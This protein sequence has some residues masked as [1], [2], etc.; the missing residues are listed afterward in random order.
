[1]QRE[2]NLV[3]SLAFNYL[4][5][6]QFQNVIRV[7]AS[8]WRPLW[9]VKDPWASHC[10]T[11]PVEICTMSF[12]KLE[13]S[14]KM[15]NN[16]VKALSH[17]PLKVMMCLDGPRHNYIRHSVWTVKCRA[18]WSIK[19]KPKSQFGLVWLC[20]CFQFGSLSCASRNTKCSNQLHFNIMWSTLV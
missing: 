8:S 10:R 13:M 2:A 4:T 16:T 9:L 5:V 17:D 14:Y 19:I 18:S 15:T 20:I 7:E 11:V 1:M 12:K 3:R 6:E